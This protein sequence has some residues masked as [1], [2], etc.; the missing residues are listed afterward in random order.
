MR[1]KLVAGNWK[2]NGSLGLVEAFCSRFQG[3]KLNVDVVIIP[4]Y[5]YVPE[6]ISKKPEA[7][8]V[9]VQN[10]SEKLAGA[11]TGEVSLV[12]AEEMRVGFSLFG[13]SERRQAF[14]ETDQLVSEKVQLAIKSSNVT[15]ILCVGETLE[16]RESGQEFLVIERQI[17]AVLDCVSVEDLDSLII[18]YEPVWAIGT[19]K[20]A[21]PDQA[22]E[23]HAFIRELV[24]SYSVTAADDMRILYGGSVNSLIAKELFSC[25]D[26]DGALVGGAS[27]KVDEFYKICELAG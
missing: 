26:I 5:L 18:A 2:M 19:G 23:I 21:T 9:G 13:H 15:P 8:G 12:M 22:Q 24:L 14:F 4:P 10:L 11:Y 25:A 27:L 6:L 20:T 7:F 17:K 16:E 3:S 1:R